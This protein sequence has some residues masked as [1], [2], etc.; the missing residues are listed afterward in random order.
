M[1]HRLLPLSLQTESASR[2]AGS[3]SARKTLAHTPPS[4]SISFQVH[5]INNSITEKH[6]HLDPPLHHCPTLRP[7]SLNPTPLS[8]PQNP[9]H[10]AHY[11]PNHPGPTSPPSNPQ[12]RT[13]KRTPAALAT[14]SRHAR[15]AALQRDAGS[16]EC[17]IVAERL[18]GGPSTQP[19]TG[20]CASILLIRH[21][22]PGKA[23]RREP[24]GN[25]TAEGRG[26]RGA[27]PWP[28]NK[29]GE[30]GEG[31]VWRRGGL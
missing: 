20:L 27:C 24:R 21:L 29:I 6:F 31:A 16:A 23:P 15:R 17:V 13:G 22:H 9:T 8:R 10:H 25:V 2:P 26:H 5:R 30:G 18:A 14:A 7:S 11:S 1:H 12:R 4:L 3:T 28:W 19:R